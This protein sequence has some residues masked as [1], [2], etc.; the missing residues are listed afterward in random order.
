LIEWSRGD[1]RRGF[2]GLRRQIIAARPDVVFIPTG[3]YIDAEKIPV[4]TMIRNM[5]PLLIPFRGNPW[6][7]PVR[8]L[9][10]AWE[11]KRAAGR[12]RRTVAVSNFVRDFLIARWH[13]DPRK[14]GVVAHGVE[15]PTGSTAA[16]TEGNAASPFL[17]AAGSIRP[18]RGFEDAIR[19][20]ALL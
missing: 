13:I 18:A 17:F 7:E 10:R 6:S 8:N 3:R 15:L 12:A 5:E 20:L 19:A 14:V 4:V 9:A 2:A 16:T 1:G 11:A